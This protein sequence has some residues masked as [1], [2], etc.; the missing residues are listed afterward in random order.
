MCEIV[1]IFSEFIAAG[2]PII[3]FCLIFKS[4]F[5]L[6]LLNIFGQYLFIYSLTKFGLDKDKDFQILYHFNYIVAVT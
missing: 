4:Y 2:S 1:S 6:K 5:E 3:I